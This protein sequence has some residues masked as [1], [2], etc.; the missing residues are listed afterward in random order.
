VF[1][2]LRGDSV[3]A[4]PQGSCATA[5]PTGN[6]LMRIE[7]SHDSM[8]TET[9]AARPAEA[10]A[11]DGGVGVAWA[12][13]T[14]HGAP[15]SASTEQLVT[16]LARGEL[17]PHT[18]VWRP[19]WGE[20]LPAMQVAELAI[21]FPS[22]TPG[23][24][25]VARAAPDAAVAPPVPVAHYPRLRLLAKDVLAE[26]PGPPAVADS[27]GLAPARVGRRALRDRDHAQQELVTS[28]VPAAAML[29]AALAMKRLGAPVG[30]GA[31]R[32]GRLELGT[33]GEA[34]PPAASAPART[35]SPLA[36]EH[37]DAPPADSFEKPLRPA[38]GYGR[39]L[40]FGALIGGVLGL[41]SV[42]LAS[43]PATT[44]AAIAPLTPAPAPPSESPPVAPPRTLESVN[45]PVPPELPRAVPTGGENARVAP[46]GARKAPGVVQMKRPGELAV[47][48]ALR[49]SPNDRF[50][51][52]VFEFAE[53]VPGYHLE[54]VDKP[55]RACGSGDARRI[56]GDA[57]LE[58][59]FTPASAHTE[60][61]EPTLRARALR[62]ALSVVRELARTCD[63][64]GVVTWVVGTASA[65][66][67]R[68]YELSAP[69]RLVVEIEH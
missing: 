59:R 44:P 40:S 60:G 42:R 43:P 65:Q 34:A 52:V 14:E 18:L 36:L 69:P 4:A 9:D 15:E 3:M 19:G 38:R 53:R 47:L 2:E 51:R 50:D 29:E 46:A 20:W 26:S 1:D 30:K 55:I 10:G 35:L 62:P 58:V 37:G 8:L 67:Y 45:D 64:E 31:E 7:M 48:Q 28:Q 49:V 61:G 68:V 57:R 54:Y 13:A 27:Q 22:V 17:P 56:E 39:W 12:W 41:L 24:R 66:R 32:W 63:F 5:G 23:S 11:G 16:W 25:R 33:F 6:E 21:A